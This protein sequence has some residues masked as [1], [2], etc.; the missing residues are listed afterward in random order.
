MK[1]FL[2]RKT[3]LHR[4]QRQEW[5]SLCLFPC[6]F[7]LPGLY[8]CLCLL[9]AQSWAFCINSIENKMKEAMKKEKKRKKEK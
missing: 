8:L 3:L 5:H 7:L 1:F 9:H 4:H 2:A 6:L